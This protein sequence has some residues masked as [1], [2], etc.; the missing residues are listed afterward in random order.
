MY[1][2]IYM[3]V[4]LYIYIHKC[5]FYIRVTANGTINIYTKYHRTPR[6]RAL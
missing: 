4:H 1:I 6:P 5:V 2:Y 3:C